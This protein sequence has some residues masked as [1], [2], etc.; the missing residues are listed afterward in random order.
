MNSLFRRAGAGLVCFFCLVLVWSGSS[1]SEEN[2]GATISIKTKIEY[3]TGIVHRIG[4]NEIVLSDVLYK[5]SDTMKFLSR[6]G[7]GI[8]AYRFNKGEKVK[9][10]LG[11]DKKIIIVQKL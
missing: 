6:S 5:Y 9:F 1:F 2:T 11:A 3:D 7:T 4:A 8:S 10:A